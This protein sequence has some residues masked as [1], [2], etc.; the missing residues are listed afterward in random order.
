MEDV[1]QTQWDELV[2][3]L[4]VEEISEAVVDE[5]WQRF[6]I[7]LKGKALEVRYQRLVR[8]IGDHHWPGAHQQRLA[9]V[10]VANYVNALKRGG[11]IG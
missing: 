2:I 1:T 11:M 7:S 10:Q 5:A 3:P 8:W 9:R 4:T 6:R